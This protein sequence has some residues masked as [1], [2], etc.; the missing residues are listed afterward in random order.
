MKG[1]FPVRIADILDIAVIAVF[2]YFCI[3]WVRQRSSR[4]V[5]AGVSVLAALYVGAR[6][7]DMHLTSLL[8]QVGFT[9]LMVAFV[10]VFQVDIRRAFEGLVSRRMFKAGGTLSPVAETIDVLVETVFAMA[11]QRTGALIV[12]KGNEPL[13]VHVRAGMPLDGLINGPLL[14]SIFSSYSPG[15]D[16]AMIIEGNRIKGFGVY[17]PLSTKAT[18]IGTGGTRHAAALGLAERTDALTIVV[19]EER[20][21]VSVAHQDQLIPLRAPDQLRTMLTDFYTKHINPSAEHRF[22]F[23]TENLGIKFASVVVAALLWLALAYRTE[24][25]GRSYDV[26]VTYRNVPANWVVDEWHPET[27]RVSLSGIQRQFDFDPSAMHV[28]L[29]LGTLV[30]GTQSVQIAEDNVLKPAGLRVT[31]IAPSSV[32]IDAYRQARVSLPVSVDV[33]GELEGDLRIKEIQP[34]PST[35]T[36]LVRRSLLD[37]ITTVPTMPVPL[38]FIAADTSMMVGLMLPENC[39]WVAEKPESV[40]VVVD[41]E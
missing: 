12:I 39:R 32:S 31:R 14:M 17:L 1:A 3:L 37:S 34:H 16:G 30:E 19:S 4:S 21:V 33:R 23:L 6:V 38:D 8:L 13:D 18:R 15:H 24:T 22:R 27:V 9:A 40:R 26:P 28:M 5:I 7:F 10:V 36:L 20:G 41:V 35:T 11:Q 25:I 2:L 29:D